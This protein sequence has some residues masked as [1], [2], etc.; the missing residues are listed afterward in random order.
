MAALSLRP[1]DDGFMVNTTW[2]LRM[3]YKTEVVTTLS[4]DTFVWTFEE[5]II[6]TRVRVDM[7]VFFPDMSKIFLKP[8]Q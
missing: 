5:G 7:I 3:T 1:S 6:S 4:R 8:A 2:R